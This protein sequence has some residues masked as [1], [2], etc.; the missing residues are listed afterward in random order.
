MN[1]NFDFLIK[2][3]LNGN[4]YHCYYSNSS[5]HFIS[6]KVGTQV[7][8]GQGKPTLDVNLAIVEKDSSSSRICFDWQFADNDVIIDV[9]GMQEQILM[10]LKKYGKA[11]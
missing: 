1:N 4:E 6:T 2:H 7:S 9:A 5:I 8:K 3:P 11:G 10:Q